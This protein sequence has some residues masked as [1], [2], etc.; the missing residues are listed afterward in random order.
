[1]DLLC[2]CTCTICFCYCGFYLC[3]FFLIADILDQVAPRLREKGLRYDCVDGGRIKHESSTKTLYIYGYSVVSQ[4]QEPKMFTIV[5]TQY[6]QDTLSTG[7]SIK[8]KLISNEIVFQLFIISV[9]Y[10]SFI[11]LCRVLVKLITE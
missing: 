5:R 7:P 4:E 10:L 11:I 6:L 8:F 1:M 3:N 2:R 9:V